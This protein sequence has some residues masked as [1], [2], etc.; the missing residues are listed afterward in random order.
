MPPELVADAVFT[1]PWGILREKH[2]AICA[3]I[4]LKLAGHEAA[5]AEFAFSEP[6]AYLTESGVKVIPVRGVMGKRMN[7]LSAF[8]GGMSTE[9]M[10]VTIQ[11]ALGDDEVKALVLDIDSPGGVVDGAAAL[12]EMVFQGRGRKPIVAFADGCCASMAYWL[13]SA[14][15]FIVANEVGTVGSIGILVSHIDRSGADA[16]KGIVR[17]TISAGSYK[18]AASDDKPLDLAG[19]EYL[20]SQVDFIYGLFVDKVARNRGVSVDKTLTMADGKVF[21]GQAALD[22]GLVD[23][24]GERHVAI[25][26]AESRISKGA[27]PYNPFEQKQQAAGYVPY[28]PL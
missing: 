13:A 12:A 14:C 26:E 16:K 9:R 15:D 8:S 18:V 7:L 5:A 4:E 20:Q 19:R 24:V 17:T 2:D 27:A 28:D 22:V 3:L 10:G 23:R 21:I 11:E 6:K 25:A 1:S